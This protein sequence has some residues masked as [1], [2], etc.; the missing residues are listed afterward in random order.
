MYS[1]FHSLLLVIAGATQKELARQVK[2]LKVENET[3]RAKLPGRITI[4]SKERQRLLKFGKNLG[5]K[6]INAVVGIVS[7]ATFLRWIREDKKAS[8][9]KTKL[10]PAK[11]GRKRTPEQIQKLILKLGRETGWGYTRILGELKKLG[12]RA[13]TRNTVKNILKAAGLDPGPK[14]GEGTWD[15]FL[16]Q[17]AASLWQCDFFSQRVLTT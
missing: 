12:I 15:E 17:H 16:K 5:S 9:R 14:R 13:I 10:P 3:L 6:A 1:I 8:K 4:T 11:R 2:Y 7:P